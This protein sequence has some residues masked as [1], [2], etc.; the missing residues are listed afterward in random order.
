[1]DLIRQAK[2]ADN[3]NA[4]RLLLTTSQWKTFRKH[5]KASRDDIEQAYLEASYIMYD[6][7]LPYES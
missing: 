3:E 5:F 1:M 2:E 4:I 7:L 6:F